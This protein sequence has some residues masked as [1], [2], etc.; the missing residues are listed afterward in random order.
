MRPA[1]RV[2]LVG[3]NGQFDGALRY[4]VNG[5]ERHVDITLPWPIDQHVVRAHA[6]ELP[7]R[8]AIP[9]HDLHPVGHRNDLPTVR[10][11]LQGDVLHCTNSYGHD[12]CLHF[13]ARQTTSMV[14]WRLDHM[15]RR[16]RAQR[17]PIV[18]LRRL[19]RHI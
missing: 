9:S 3:G 12:D 7:F 14:F 10:A 2:N 1:H 11:Y 13:S 17:S 18:S 15:V 19:P 4:P 16:L 8:H 5:V 6:F